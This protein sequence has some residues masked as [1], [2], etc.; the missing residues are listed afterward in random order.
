MR[1]TK[2]PL[3]LGA[4]SLLA[5]TACTDP[6]YQQG[7]ER[8]RTGQGAAIGAA[9]GGVLGA[10]RESGSD[11]IRNAAVGAAIGAAVGGAIGYSLDQQAAE[12]RNDFGNSEIDVI[13]TGS[14]LIVRMPEAIL[15]ATDS[16][17]L[18]SQLR[19]D[20]FV[21]SDSLNKYPQSTVTVTGH[22]DST[23]TAAYNQDLSERRASSVASVLQQGGVS[24]S[25]IRVVGA[26]ESQPIATNQTAAGR[27]QNRRVDI[28][29]T[30]TG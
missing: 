11:R 26:G 25:R 12:L 18:N 30:P 9:I 16:A 20:L 10:T 1:L 22:T 17:A 21:L 8:Q 23:G 6:A 5:L 24:G 3:I 28:T 14:E 2:K 19:S 29:I 15:F 27:Q 4:A 7:G 13:N